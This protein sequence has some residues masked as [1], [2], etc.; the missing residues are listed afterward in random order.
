MW[1]RRSS[2]WQQRQ[3]GHL[4]LPADVTISSILN[5]SIPMFTSWSIRLEAFSTFPQG[6]IA[7]ALKFSRSS[8][9]ILLWSNA[10][11][12][13]SPNVLWRVRHPVLWSELFGALFALWP[14]RQQ[15]RPVQDVYTRNS[16]QFA[17][18]IDFHS[19][20]SANLLFYLETS[21]NNCKKM[22]FLLRK[23]D[24]IAEFSIKS[25]NF[26]IIY[27]KIAYDG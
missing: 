7:I 22:S 6:S 12:G 16:K 27:Y 4:R 3:P 17:H 2:W 20:T 18:F 8:L 19:M 15:W 21:E 10:S 11:S 9:G 23:T 26:A 1:S 14:Q 24:I 5:V 25:S 13:S